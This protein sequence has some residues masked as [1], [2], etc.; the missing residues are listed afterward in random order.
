MKSA[1]AFLF[2][3]IFYSLAQAA[4]WNPIPC[5]ATSKCPDSAPCC[6]QYGMCG[7][8]FYCLGGCDPRYSFNL[9]ACMPQ[10][11]MSSFQD[12]MSN[13]SKIMDINQYLGNASQAD[14][15]Y[16][17]YINNADG[18]LLLQMPNQSTGTVVSS[19]K[20]LWFGRV[21]AT[22]KTARDVGVVTAFITFSDVQDEIDYEFMG[23]DLEKPQTNFYS[24]GL[25]NYTNS[26]NYTTTDTYE[27]YH[28][29]EIDWAEDQTQWIIDGNV[30]RTLKR[31]DTWNLTKNRYDYPST[32][33]RVQFSLWP[34]GS[35]LNALGTVQ[36]AGGP[37]NWNSQDIQDY[38][39][40]YA[41]VKNVSIKAYDLPSFVSGNS[42]NLS[43]F[44]YNST[45]DF[46]EENVLLTNKKTWL[47]NQKAVGF[48]PQ[49]D[50]STQSSQ[51]SKSSASSSSSNTKTTKTTGSGS[52][53]TGMPI[54]TD[55]TTSNTFV[56]GFVQ[57][58]STSAKGGSAS[59]SK[60]GAGAD[61]ASTAIGGFLAMIAGVFVF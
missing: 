1:L 24:L 10:P 33:S 35:D 2:F 39:Y 30:V 49:N 51:S 44:L 25:L 60:S 57:G 40:Y 37:I 9:T 41:Y 50:A 45:T 5:N 19:T 16:T 31:S 38:G 28:Y 11:R 43:A 29:Y 15:V 52:G 47:G 42:T 8:G 27:N 20:Y 6:N 48:N 54:V 12:L 53:S 23:Y 26:K 36:W 22:I 55:S 46:N 56:G 34:A 7:T 14:W 13:A 61:R 58:G 59:A 17:G 3:G 18:A 4:D 32:P 21:G